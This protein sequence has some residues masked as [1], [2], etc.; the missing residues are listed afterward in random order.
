MEIKAAGRGLT[1]AE[2]REFVTEVVSAAGDDGTISI[3]GQV[4]VGGALKSLK[5][6]ITRRESG[7]GA[8]R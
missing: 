2:L 3:T 1:L 4:R 7:S 5:A 8:G 6:V